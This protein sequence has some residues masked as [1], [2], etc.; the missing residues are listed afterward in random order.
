MDIPFKEIVKQKQNHELLKMVYE[1][2]E[3]SPEM[4]KAV[5][6]ELEER[7]M[8]PNDISAKKQQAIIE[9]E[10]NLESG[11]QASVMGQVL[12]WLFVLGFLGLYIG[13]NYMSSKVRSKYTGKKYYKYNADSRENGSYI[14]YT[15]IGAL[16][17]GFFYAV[18]KWN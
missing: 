17:L 13:Y 12:G 14:F 9:E 8:L 7:K 18:Y 11:K 10:A 3:W 6:A 16:I 5:E 4:L 2:R 15:S 1:F